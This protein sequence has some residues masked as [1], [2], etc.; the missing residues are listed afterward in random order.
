LVDL[1]TVSKYTYE[2][3]VLIAP[4]TC[5]RILSLELLNDIVK[6]EYNKIKLEIVSN[7]EV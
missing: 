3:E 5:F 6:G 7:L 1:K 2:E 4:L